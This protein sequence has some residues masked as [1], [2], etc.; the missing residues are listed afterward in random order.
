MNRENCVGKPIIKTDNQSIR[1]WYVANVEAIPEW[2]AGVEP[3]RAKAKA[4][5]YMRNWLKQT[6]RRAME[7]TETAGLLE[8]YRPVPKFDDLLKK[9]MREKGL[10][11]K[12][13]LEDILETASKT[14][15]NVNEEFGI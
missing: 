10:T 13:A 12:E 5:F 15:R 7:D 9:K 8:K 1:E 6:A 4:A 2:V 3:L 14:N 11:R